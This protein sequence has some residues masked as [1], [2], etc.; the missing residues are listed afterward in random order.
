MLIP[1]AARC[2]ELLSEPGSAQGGGGFVPWFRYCARAA[3]GETPIA[4]FTTCG[5]SG[6]FH[7][8]LKLEEC[9]IQDDLVKEKPMLVPH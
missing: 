2:D 4:S 6:V 1:A 7:W 9:S 3:V 5:H 8:A